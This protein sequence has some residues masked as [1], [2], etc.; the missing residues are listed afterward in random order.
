MSRDSTVFRP[1]VEF[2]EFDYALRNCKRLYQP[3]KQKMTHGLTYTGAKLWNDFR[4]II[5]DDTDLDDF[6]ILAKNLHEKSL[7]PTFEYYV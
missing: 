2:K 3:K 5:T 6:K 4:P 7:D 1:P